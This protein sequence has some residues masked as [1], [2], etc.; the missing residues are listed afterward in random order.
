MQFFCSEELEF[1]SKVQLTI[2]AVEVLLNNNTLP[3][4][5]KLFQFLIYREIGLLAIVLR[6]IAG[7][8]KHL[9][10]FSK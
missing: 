5:G 4:F 10:F 6:L 9:L 7:V 3:V 8:H 2:D 1:S